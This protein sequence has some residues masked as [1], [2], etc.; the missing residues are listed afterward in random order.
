MYYAPEIFKEVGTG[1]NAAF[2]RDGY[3][4]HHM[5]FTFVAIWLVDQLCSQSPAGIRGALAYFSLPLVVGMVLF[6]LGG[7]CA[8]DLP[9]ALI[10]YCLL[11]PL[12]WMPSVILLPRFSRSLRGWYRRLQRCPSAAAVLVTQ[13]FLVLVE[14]IGPAYTFWIFF[15]V[16]VVLFYGCGF[17][18]PKGRHGGDRTELVRESIGGV[19]SAK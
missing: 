2:P 7:A 3:W 9:T 6:Q 16:S 8:V 17:R 12:R 1:A 13:L 11:P 4:A 19:L 15:A 18:K 14:G 10:K 5:L